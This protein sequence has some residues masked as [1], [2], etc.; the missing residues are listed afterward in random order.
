MEEFLTENR[1]TRCPAHE[2]SQVCHR[3]RTPA[4]YAHSFVAPPHLQIT[5]TRPCVPANL[6][7]AAAAPNS[8]L[9]PTSPQLGLSLSVSSLAQRT[10]ACL[11]R[12][13]DKG[14]WPGLGFI[15]VEPKS[16]SGDE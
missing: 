12:L 2:K 15:P 16:P 1:V 9:S 8:F 6:P 10:I 5:H 4:R 3:P 14:R 7:M 11:M 13:V